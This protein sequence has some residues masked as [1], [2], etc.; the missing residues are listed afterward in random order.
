MVGID[1]YTL[2]NA[3]FELHKRLL[4]NEILILENLVDLDRIHVRAF[5]LFI[6]PLKLEG[7]DGAP[8][9]VVAELP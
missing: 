3:P 1:S 7:M 8:C 9:R 4:E 6:F 2:D 5:K